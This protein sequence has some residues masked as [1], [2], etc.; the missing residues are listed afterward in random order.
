[1][2]EKNTEKNENNKVERVRIAGYVVTETMELINEFKDNFF[3]DTKVKLTIGQTLDYIV[4]IAE[5][6]IL[7]NMKK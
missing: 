4:G 3:K 7:K 1:M 5:F 2:T 6:D